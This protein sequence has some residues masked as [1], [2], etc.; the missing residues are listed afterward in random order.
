MY[1]EENP[2]G[3][4][5]RQR[6]VA[7]LRSARSPVRGTD[8]AA[9]LGVSRQVIVQDV[10]LLRA[11]GEPIVATPRGYAL[12]EASPAPRHRAVLAV[13][14]HRAQTEDELNL[15]VDLGLRVVDVLVEHPIYGE[16]RGSLMLDSREDV[17]QFMEQLHRSGAAL[18]SE[19][20]G[21]VHLHTVEAPR[22]ELLARAQEE[23]RRRG[24]LLE[25]RALSE[26]TPSS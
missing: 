14:H 8:L 17:R 11:S 20:T 7:L 16:I 24:Y 12:V 23:L 25:E 15:L 18:L 19:L 3:G 13:R 6:I 22:L 2:S 4:E 26:K 9:Q 5:R 1:H 21:G 10:A